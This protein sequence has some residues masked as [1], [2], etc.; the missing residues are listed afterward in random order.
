MFNAA[1]PATQAV[2]MSSLQN[3]W[4]G[5]VQMFD[6]KRISMNVLRY[7]QLAA[8]RRRSPIPTDSSIGTAIAF[9][10]NGS[11]TDLAPDR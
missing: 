9:R 8:S 6:N 5:E 3:S 10:C 2:G 1:Q 7:Q 11:G 4:R